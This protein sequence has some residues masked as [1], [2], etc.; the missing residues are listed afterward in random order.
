ML[1]SARAIPEI[2]SIAIK[3]VIG[4]DSVEYNASTA[5]AI[6]LTA[7]VTVVSSGRSRVRSTS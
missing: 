2:A 4:L 6:A 3:S 5:C 1:G 7:L